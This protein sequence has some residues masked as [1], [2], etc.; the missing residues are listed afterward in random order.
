MTTTTE[1]GRD[2]LLQL[3]RIERAI[4]RAY[5]PVL[6]SLDLRDRKGLE[7][8]IKR[9]RD[10]IKAEL[11]AEHERG[12]DEGLHDGELEVAA[13]LQFRGGSPTYDCVTLADASPDALIE[14]AKA[15]MV[16]VD[17]TALERFRKNG[18]A[19]WADTIWRAQ[20]PG[21]GSVALLIERGA[22]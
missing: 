20:M 3:E 11:E 7:N 17:H 6:D 8:E 19:T 10:G 12:N 1:T 21:T 5:Q 16:R 9:L 15:G 2:F 4:D 22:K 18:G 14:A 13:K